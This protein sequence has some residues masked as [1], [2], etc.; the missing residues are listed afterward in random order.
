[1]A[2]GD[3]RL[4][5]SGNLEESLAQLQELPGI[6]PWTAQL[7]AMRAL[8]EPDALPAGDLG[9]R[10]SFGRAGKLASAAE[11]EARAEAWRPWR[12]YG[13]MLF[14]GQAR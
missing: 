2:G 3:L 10:R 11:V 13:A 1:V 4:D 12:A 5:S 7:I 8:G 6:G 9:L 14:W